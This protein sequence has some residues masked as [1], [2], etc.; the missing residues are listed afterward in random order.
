MSYR[1][2]NEYNS[3]INVSGIKNP[4]KFPSNTNRSVRTVD[5]VESD[6]SPVKEDIHEN[7]TD[8][9]Y[10][11]YIYD[12]EVKV[13]ELN[14]KEEK[15]DIINSNNLV[16]VDIWGKFCGPC[17]QISPLYKN[18]CK[19]YNNPPNC[20]LV[21]EDCTLGISPDVKGVP[22]FEFY[23]KGKMVDKVIGADI[24]TVE[25]KINKYLG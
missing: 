6:I 8:S 14:S 21:K 5:H 25:N 11:K 16:V 15:Y 20:L 19:K 2:Y 10:V 23:L 7:T 3:N 22:T 1:K 18:L 17:K 13:H 12:K 9:K 24:T 4:N